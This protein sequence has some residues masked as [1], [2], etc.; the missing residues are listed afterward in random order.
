MRLLGAGVTVALAVL[1]W[2]AGPAAAG[3]QRIEPLTPAGQ[4]NVQAR[5]AVAVD[6]ATG[7]TLYAKDADAV[8][9]I[10]STSKIFVA[11]VVRRRGIDLDGLTAITKVDR[12]H[13]R[14]GARTRLEV[15]HSFRNIDLLRA[16]LIASDNRAPTALGRAVNL[17]PGALVAAMNELAA[18][19]G[20]TRTRF[21]D[22]SGLNGNVST[23]RE[24]AIAF[25][26][27]LK[28]PLLAELMGAREVSVRSTH[29]R[30][31]LIHYR[32]SNRAL[33]SDSYQVLGGKTGY[34][35]EAGYCL[36]ISARVAGRAL[37]MVFLGED[38][39]LTRYGDFERV[40]QWV[41]E[42]RAP[43]LD[44]LPNIA[45]GGPTINAAAVSAGAL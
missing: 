12:D 9:A 32:N 43:P 6:I 24:M 18:E 28:D 13:A 26:A 5:A 34:T 16:M 45:G 10:A 2:V 23:A 7:G 27:A 11:M 21:T 38:H 3:G 41:Q 14:G 20:L 29:S 17:E 42:G 4:P 33:H 37:L 1:S 25:R 15:H 35:R 39:E 19:L 30:P 22:P 36:L 40:T 31:M 8:R 44:S